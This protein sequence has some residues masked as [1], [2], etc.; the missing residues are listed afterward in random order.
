MLRCYAGLLEFAATQG[1][2]VLW[3][4]L[5]GH[6]EVE[7]EAS[8]KDIMIYVYKLGRPWRQCT[9]IKN[10]VSHDTVIKRGIKK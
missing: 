6:K 3:S 1:V 2:L 4:I 9:N 7:K 5:D 10:L 8:S